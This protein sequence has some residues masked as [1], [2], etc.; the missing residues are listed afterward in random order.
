MGRNEQEIGFWLLIKKNFLIERSTEGATREVVKFL[1]H[2]RYSNKCPEITRWDYYREGSSIGKGLDQ[3]FQSCDSIIY[4]S[5]EKSGDILPEGNKHH[6]KIKC[7]F[8]YS[9]L[10]FNIYLSF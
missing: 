8:I 9:V 7:E 1:C 4:S 6:L 2:C 10:L 5:L 3:A